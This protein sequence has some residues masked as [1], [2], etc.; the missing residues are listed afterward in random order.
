MW[1]HLVVQRTSSFLC[2]NIFALLFWTRKCSIVFRYEAVC[3]PF[4]T[5]KSVGHIR[6]IITIYW[7]SSFIVAIPQLFIFEQSFF[8][9]N[10]RKYRCTST[11]YTAEWQRRVYFTIFAC[12]VLVLPAV[13]MTIWY[14]R[15][16]RTID[17][18]KKNLDTNY[19]WSNTNTFDSFT[20]DSN[21]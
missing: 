3:C 8:P 19:A 6:R 13:C 11:G 12:Y 21:G 2:L 15:I 7:F 5:C 20:T 9:G 18:S 10:S 1:F 4:G 17:K 16:I 14:I